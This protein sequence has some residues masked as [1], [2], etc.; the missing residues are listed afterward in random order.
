M[1]KL[2]ISSTL[3]AKSHDIIGGIERYKDGSL[4]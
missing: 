4:T 1:L 2:K 3:Q